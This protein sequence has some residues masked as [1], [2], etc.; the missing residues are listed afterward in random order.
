MSKNNNQGGIFLAG[1]LIGGAV[2][3]VLG[4]LIAPRA[5][6]DTQRLVKKTVAALPELAEDIASSVQ[7]QAHRL[8]DGARHQ[9]DDTLLRLRE[10]IAAGIEASQRES[11][12]LQTPEK[13]P[14]ESNSLDNRL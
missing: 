14:L 10:S 7:L 9:W 1:I 3:T 12:E 6:K 13:S 4:L 11:Q 8:S 5:G 2:G